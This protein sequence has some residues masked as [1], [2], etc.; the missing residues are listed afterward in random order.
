MKIT[1]LLAFLCFHTWSGAQD[2]PSFLIGKGGGITG[3]ATVYRVTSSG[4]IFKGQGIGDIKYT[5]CGKVKR[6][7]AK[8]MISEVATAVDA[9]SFD[10]PGNIYYFITLKAVEGEKKI[11]WG[12]AAHEVPRPVKELY[13]EMVKALSSI[14]YRPIDSN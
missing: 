12:D 9:T 5:E 6:A 3:M 11:T 8:R 13:D 1:V 2:Q 7:H 4:K 10:H 14:K